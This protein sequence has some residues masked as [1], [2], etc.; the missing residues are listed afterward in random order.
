MLFCQQDQGEQRLKANKQREKKKN[1]SCDSPF[2][3]RSRAAS[4]IQRFKKTP[5]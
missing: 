1:R 5:P 3:D 4:I 2:R